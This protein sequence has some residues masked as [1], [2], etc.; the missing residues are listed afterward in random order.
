MT[1]LNHRPVL[2]EAFERICRVGLPV[3]YDDV[4]VEVDPHVMFRVP[5]A[6]TCV[7]ITSWS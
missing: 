3:S 2:L 5:Q 1:T 7:S 4:I 6:K